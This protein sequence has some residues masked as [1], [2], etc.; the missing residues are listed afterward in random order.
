MSE[1]LNKPGEQV[2]HNQQ[3]GEMVATFPSLETIENQIFDRTENKLGRSTTE[4]YAELERKALLT[5]AA[6][7]LASVLHED[8]RSSRKLEDGSFE[9]REKPTKDVEW[10]AKHGVNTVDIANTSYVDLPDDW[11]KENREAAEVVVSLLDTQVAPDLTVPAVR[12]ELGTKIHDAWLAR[13]E[14]AKGGELGVP[15]SQL[16]PQEQ[17]KDIA[18]VTM[19]IQLFRPEQ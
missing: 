10:V 2:A 13:N 12:D 8:W 19:G 17:E 6:D 3:Q 4:M 7:S 18:Q 14:W 15:F 9:P 16:P 1:Q 11:K 5:E